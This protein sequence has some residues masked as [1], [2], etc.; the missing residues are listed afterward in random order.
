MGWVYPIFLNLNF[1]ATFLKDFHELYELFLQRHDNDEKAALA[2]L[3]SAAG[4]RA[5]RNLGDDR[6]LSQMALCIFQAGFVWRV[7]VDKW[8]NFELAF[9]KF[10]PAVVAHFSDD[11]TDELMLDTGI[12]RNRQKIL[13]VR[14]NA[15]FVYL[16]SQKSEG[17]G[18]WISDWPS[19]DIVGLWQEL[20]KRGSRLGGNTGPRVLRLVGKDTFLLTEDVCRALLRY[21][22]VSELSPTSLRGQRRAEK[23][24]LDLQQQSG[25]SLCMLSRML[26]FTV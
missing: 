12:I 9:N 17:F 26:S 19:E 14:E 13:A 8:D 18:R 3:P 11:R 7:V 1:R 15:A 24:F 25:W 6:Y 20:K 21:G 10:K 2:S 23:A 4:V 16:Q 5:L 22:L